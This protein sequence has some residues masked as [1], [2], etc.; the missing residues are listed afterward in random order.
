ME[1]TI[2][3][4]DNGKCLISPSI[5]AADFTALGADVARAEKAGVEMIHVDVMDPGIASVGLASFGNIRR[6]R[7]ESTGINNNRTVGRG[8]ND[9]FPATA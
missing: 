9:I 3:E 4:M 6:L 1:S 7:S 5:L 2:A 8:E